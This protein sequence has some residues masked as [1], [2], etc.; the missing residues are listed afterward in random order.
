[1]AEQTTKDLRKILFNTINAVNEKKLAAEDARE[2]ARLAGEI[3]RSAELE[4]KYARAVADLKE[5]NN[6][7]PQAIALTHEESKK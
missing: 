5:S 1:M 7:E 3:I 6:A 2:V 4:I